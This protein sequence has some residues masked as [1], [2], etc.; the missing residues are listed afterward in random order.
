LSPI[1]H[2]G[3]GKN[4]PPF[5]ILHVADRPD[6]KVQSQLFAGRLNEVGGGESRCR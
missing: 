4:I 5:L 3:K 1:T 2:V 6:S